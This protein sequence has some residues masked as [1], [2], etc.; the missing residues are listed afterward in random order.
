MPIVSIEKLP[1]NPLDA[2]RQIV[3]GE[4]QLGV[5]RSELVAKCRAQGST[6]EEIASVLG[7]SRQSAWQYYNSRFTKQWKQWVER[8]EDL[9]EEAAMHLAI[10]ETRAVRRRRQT[11]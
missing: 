10:E 11:K 9:S 8:N 2:L 7:I 3:Q 4:A 6:W 1:P 5:A